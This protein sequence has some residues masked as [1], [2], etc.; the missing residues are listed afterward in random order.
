MT[1]SGQDIIYAAIDELN[2]QSE[3]GIIIKKSP[4]TKVF[5]GDGGF[6]SLDLVN[7]VIAIET[8]IEDTPGEAVLLIDKSTMESKNNPFD[9]VATLSAYV[10]TLLAEI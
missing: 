8:H 10:D 1:T 4:E 2:A 7:L 6:N 3:D 9:N 5:G